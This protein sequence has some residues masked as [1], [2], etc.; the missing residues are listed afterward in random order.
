MRFIHISDVHLGR[1]PVGSVGEY[2]N[3]RFND[4]FNAFDY[5]VEKAIEQK[6]DAVII[7]G[8]FFDRREISPDIL[9]RA[10]QIL[11]KLKV[12][13]IKVI[14]IEGNH[15]NIT[16][17]SEID[18]WIVYLSQKGLLQRPA[19]CFNEDDKYVFEPIEVGN[20]RFYGI[21]YPGSFAQEVI[22]ALAE[23]L[24]ENTNQENIVIV[25]TAIA[26]EDLVPGTVDSSTINLLRNKAIYIA[27]GHLHS[28]KVYPKENPLLFIPGSLEYFDLG[29]IGQQKGFIL[30]D[31][32][33][34]Q[35][36]WFASKCRHSVRLKLNSNATDYTE[37]EKEFDE[38][39][40]TAALSES[41]LVYCEINLK[42][43]FFVDTDL[44]KEKLQQE[45][46]LKAKI[47]IIFPF[48]TISDISN[49]NMT[50]EQIERAIISTWNEFSSDIELT[51]GK[52]NKFKE[53]QSENNF[54]VFYEEFDDYFEQLI[55]K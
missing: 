15:D 20:C 6:V 16:F 22:G 28:Y 46:A 27:G 43:S 39:I 55:A 49:S 38:L 42:S 30:F 5:A 24:A 35:H 47:R 37:L 32:D 40:S 19:Y 34:K 3:L 23:Q 52:L 54:D 1:R 53:L 41:C 4:Y 9:Q 2:S 50:I 33:T 8:D 11:N 48:S 26:G 10:E 13:D 45:G 7:A 51:A 21:G 29:E 25:H 12:N 36:E 17:G 44:F 31:T 18:S 14:L